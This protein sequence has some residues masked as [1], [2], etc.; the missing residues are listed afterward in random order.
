MRSSRTE[1]TTTALAI[2]FGMG[3]TFGIG[4]A[5]GAISGQSATN[6]D[7]TITY[8]FSWTGTTVARRDALIDADQ[9]STTGFAIGGIF[10]EYLLQDGGLWHFTGVNSGDWS[11]AFVKNLT[12]AAGSPAQWTFN[13]A[14][15]GETNACSE[16]SKI[17]FRTEDAAGGTVD[18][19]PA[20]THTFTPSS[21]CGASMRLG[22]ASYFELGTS[23]WTNVEQS[24]ADLAFVVVNPES[25][26]GSSSNTSWAAEMSRLQSAGIAIYGYIKS[27]QAGVGTRAR[28]AADYVTDIDRW[29]MWYGTHLTGLFI[30]EE[31]PQCTSN[32]G[33]NGETGF[34]EVQYYKNIVAYMKQSRDA[35]AAS[36]GVKI[37]LNQ[38][39]RTEQCMFT[40]NNTA[41]PTQDVIQANFESDLAAY[42][43]WSIPAGSW[44]LNYPASKFW[45]LIHTAPTT[46]DLQEAISLARTVAKHTGNVYVTDEKY[47]PVTFVGCDATGAG[48]WNMLPGTCHNDASYWPLEKQLTD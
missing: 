18:V 12:F 46:T 40:V 25:G 29:Y 11:W 35:Y 4:D 45:N 10:A 27:R 26:P 30:D 17:V 32:L 39:S 36:G 41:D 42:R 14:D 8:S 24:G 38:G 48:T 23:D 7:T 34:N 33:P 6:T 44:E 47:T 21:T 9:L 31:Y 19:A 43:G 16:S 3:V 22:V 13:R 28:V 5:Q 2:L 37:I 15:I 1:K 20:Y